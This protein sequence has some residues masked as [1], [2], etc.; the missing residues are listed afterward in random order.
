[1]DRNAIIANCKKYLGR[2]YVWGG[3]SMAEGGYDCSGYAYNVLRDSGYPVNRTTAQGYSKLG[4]A[5]PYSKA[6]IGDLLFFGKSASAITHIA[7]YAG[8]GN[9]YESIGGS[10]NTKNNPG[11]GVSLSK[12]SRRNNLILVKSIVDDVTEETAP[13]KKGSSAGSAKMLK[14]DGLWG[15]STTERLQEI[16]GT[17][18]DGIISS[19]PASERT[20]N[21]GLANM[22]G[23]GWKKKPASGSLLI[24]ALQK[25]VGVAQD[26]WIS[27]KTI[28][29]IQKRLGTVQDGVIGN[30]SAMVKAL[31]KW[32]NEQK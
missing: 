30:P 10:K 6:G 31:Q 18:K 29:A 28:M 2:P 17:Q 15:P 13:P 3:E 22:K 23:W 25:K 21:P 1:M 4:K 20:R 14:I 16:F 12:V 32:C 11:K 7:F 8:N 5:V 19:Q 9:M 26:G 24:K 27:K